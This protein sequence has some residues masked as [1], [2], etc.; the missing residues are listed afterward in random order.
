M[1][2]T[3]T[4]DSASAKINLTVNGMREKNRIGET[5][6][7][8]INLTDTRSALRKKDVSTNSHQKRC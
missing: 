4:A 5:T 3:N 8:G 7:S 1:L 6:T 2:P